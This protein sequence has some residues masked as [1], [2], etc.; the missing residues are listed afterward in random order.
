MD[1]RKSPC[2]A[3]SCNKIHSHN[4]WKYP[5]LCDSCRKHVKFYFL[6]RN[7]TF[8]V[9]EDDFVHAINQKGQAVMMY[10]LNDY[11]EDGCVRK[12]IYVKYK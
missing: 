2:Q 7:Q 12:E 5:E 3:E 1:L 11:D 6:C 10:Y 8:E 4:G 9:F